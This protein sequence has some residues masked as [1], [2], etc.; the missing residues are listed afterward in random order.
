MLGVIEKF[1]SYLIDEWFEPFAH[2]TQRNLYISSF[3]LRDICLIIF[4]VL[5]LYS[6]FFTQDEVTKK[7]F[8]S[9]LTY[10]LCLIYML[11]NGFLEDEQK[12]KN[13]KNMAIKNPARK[14]PLSRV[15]IWPYL[16]VAP[17]YASDHGFVDA[18]AIFFI[19]LTVYFAACTPLPPGTK[20]ERGIF[21][22]LK[23]AF[24]K[25]NVS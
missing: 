15:L 14:S 1:D 20:L 11:Y 22:F 9:V 18:I 7:Y 3:F 13:A 4:V 2:W 16:I 24:V 23:L 25:N 10:F 17:F 5:G 8:F 21:G 6:I 12:I 19:V